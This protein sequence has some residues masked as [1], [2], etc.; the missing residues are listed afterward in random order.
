[1]LV[2]RGKRGFK[3]ACQYKLPDQRAVI[4]QGCAYVAAS[5]QIAS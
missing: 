5:F 1:M 2:Y 4:L 3:I